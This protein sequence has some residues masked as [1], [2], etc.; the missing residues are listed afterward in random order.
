MKPARVYC[1][2]GSFGAPCLVSSDAL[3]MP[4]EF[5]G[6]YIYFANPLHDLVLHRSRKQD[7]VASDRQE[8][9]QIVEFPT[10]WTICSEEF[11]RA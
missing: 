1:C 5:M 4:W 7:L 11:H 8:L 10:I 2:V 9:A 3:G 6:V